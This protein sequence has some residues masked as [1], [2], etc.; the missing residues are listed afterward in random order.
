MKKWLLLLCVTAVSADEIH[1]NQFEA[2]V[3]TRAS[4]LV[5]KDPHFLIPVST[6]CLDRTADVNNEL[7]IVLTQ[8]NDG[9]GYLDLN[10]VTLY[11]SDQPRHLSGLPIGG[12]FHQ[13]DCPSPLFSAPCELSVPL[14]GDINTAVEATDLCLGVI[15]GTDSGYLPA[16]TETN[17]PCHV[18][19]PVDL[20]LNLG[21]LVLPLRDYQQALNYQDGNLNYTDG[22]HRGFLTEA[23]A[24]ATLIPPTV[25]FVGG[26]PL[27]LILPGGTGNCALTDDRD[28]HP[29]HG[30]GWWFYF[31]S[32]GDLVETL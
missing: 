26:Q 13:P 20:T 28:T 2:L 31:N 27:S 17:G 29:M 21:T 14:L 15:A 30:S 32:V 24:D 9:D 7:D 23:D 4:Q 12:D 22:L 19:D 16:I 8:D 1:T 5:I 3:A 18:T 6:L 10:W 25:P 11:H